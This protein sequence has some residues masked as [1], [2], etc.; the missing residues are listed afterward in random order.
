MGQNKETLKVQAIVWGGLKEKVERH[1]DATQM[2][3]GAIVKTA[4]SEYYSKVN[5]DYNK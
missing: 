4:L 1:R 5:M 2:T 3:I